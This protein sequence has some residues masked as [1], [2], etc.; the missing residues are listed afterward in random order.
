MIDFILCL[1]SVIWF[2]YWSAESGASLPWSSKWQGLTSWTHKLP[3]WIIA[4]SVGTV[5]VWGW[6]TMFDV[7]P[8]IV[9]GLWLIFSGIALAGK[10]SA[11]WAYLR[12]T[13][14]TED[15]DGDGVIT[16]ADGRDST[17]FGFNN[18]IAKL[19]GYRLGDEG[20]SWMWAM[21]KGFIMTLPVGG[22][23]GAIFH[24]IGHEIG[25]HAKG[26]LSG[27]SNMWKELTG[28]GIGIGVPVIIF[29]SIVLFLT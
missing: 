14:H 7:S 21:T 6:G 23:T 19:F 16:D 3:E 17:L 5:A 18:W 20:Y 2:A 24:P 27:D 10:E 11:T 28:G 13:G 4:L 29:A 15:K 25:S 26:R 1:F 12:W 9:I 22:I 8:L